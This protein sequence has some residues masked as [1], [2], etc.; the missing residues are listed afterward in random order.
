MKKIA[1][2]GA[3]EAFLRAHVS[4]EGTLA[5]IGGKQMVASRWMCVL[6][7]GTA[8]T[9]KH[10]AAHSCGK[11]TDGCV[12]PRHLSWK[13][14][15]ENQADRVAHGTSNHGERNGKTKLTAEDIAAIRAAPADLNALVLRY[16]VSKG[17]ISKI[18]SGSRWVAL[19]FQL[20]G[21]LA[22]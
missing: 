19:D 13:T 3:T 21:G 17:C 11:G 12:N 6:A 15:V 22:L 1:D 7:H 8:P 10:E 5:V 18:R 20:T 14:P 4:H 16:G 2:K 9:Q